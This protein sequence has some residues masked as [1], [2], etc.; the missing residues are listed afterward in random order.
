MLKS[1]QVLKKIEIEE[2]KG[3]KE[4]EIDFTEFPLTAILGS[5]GVGK[6]TILHLLAC[7]NNP[8]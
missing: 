2:L 8:V 4:L 3:L 6:S 7:V 1:E 5:N